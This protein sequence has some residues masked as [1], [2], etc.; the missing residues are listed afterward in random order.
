LVQV[1]KS[2]HVLGISDKKTKS[3]VSLDVLCNEGSENIGPSGG[4]VL[5]S[6][7]RMR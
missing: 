3:L 2:E 1:K 6:R 7:L 5:H 4:L